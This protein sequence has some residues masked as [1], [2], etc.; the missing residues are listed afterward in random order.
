M[1][2]HRKMHLAGRQFR[3][4]E[5]NATFARQDVYHRH[6]Q[7]IH[8]T[9][10]TSLVSRTNHTHGDQE[11]AKIRE[12]V[13]PLLSKHGRR[14]RKR[15][16]MACDLCW[17]KKERCDVG[18]PMSDQ[19]CSNCA[20]QDT[21]CRYSRQSNKIKIP[22]LAHGGN[23]PMDDLVEHAR[24]D[25]MQSQES[26]VLPQS[27]SSSPY[28][29]VDGLSVDDDS[30]QM[31]ALVMQNRQD[32]SADAL[33]A[34]PPDSSVPAYELGLFS[35]ANAV[36][37]DPSLHDESTRT[38]H[39]WNPQLFSS[40]PHISTDIVQSWDW[41]MDE[42]I[43]SSPLLEPHRS[44]PWSWRRPDLDQYPLRHRHTGVSASN[45]PSL[46][47]PD[48]EDVLQQPQQSASLDAPH[49]EGLADICAGLGQENASLAQDHLIEPTDPNCTV[50]A[51]A[52]TSSSMHDSHRTCIYDLVHACFQT[53][54]SLS[55]EALMFKQS[56]ILEARLGLKFANI[57]DDSMDP[58]H[59]LR[60]YVHLYFRNFH[61]LWPIL[62]V[63]LF[64]LHRC[65]PHLYLTLAIIGSQFG[66]QS[67]A[68]FGQMAHQVFRTVLIGREL[69]MHEVVESGE[70]LCLT[71]LLN[72]ATALYFGQRRSFYFAQQLRTLLLIH[73]HRICLFDEARHE[74]F[75]PP[76]HNLSTFT[77][78]DDASNCYPEVAQAEVRRRIAYG[79]VRL[80]AYIALLMGQRPQIDVDDL[81]I[82]MLGDPI[83]WQGALA[84]TSSSDASAHLDG[85]D[86][87]RSSVLGGSTV[88]SSASKSTRDPSFALEAT[89]GEHKPVFCTVIRRFY[90]GM[91]D[92]LA[93]H[94]VVDQ[95]LILF[96][97][98]P[99][100]LLL[101]RQRYSLCPTIGSITEFD[102]KRRQDPDFLREPARRSAAYDDEH[103]PYAINASSHPPS[104]QLDYPMIR[105]WGYTLATLARWRQGFTSTQANAH[106]LSA[107]DRQ[108]LFHCHI[109]YSC[110]TLHLFADMEELRGLS[111]LRRRDPHHPLY[112]R[113]L[114]W[115]RSGDAQT[116]LRRVYNTLELVVDELVKRDGAE[117]TFL[118]Y[119]V[120]YHASILLWV[121]MQ[122]IE[123]QQCYGKVSAILAKVSDAASHSP[124]SIAT[125]A[126]RDVKTMVATTMLR[127]GDLYL[128]FNCRW[129]LVNNFRELIRDL[130]QRSL[131]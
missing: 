44:T 37:T 18:D 31:P 61:P 30:V 9:A 19:Q 35:L 125:A 53:K 36:Q 87:T 51:Q 16:R 124:D 4:V 67:D 41:L 78:I 34:G 24:N 102:Q 98:V 21:E 40:I 1:R 130:A 94:R 117:F 68:E 46:A 93:L 122:L 99:K 10:R 95:E 12:Q 108:N 29:P 80:D 73:A 83:W 90:A 100:V 66:T 129:P 71:M 54:Q 57:S 38:E 127:I 70:M 58:Q 48:V 126:G 116:A 104:D 84:S 32:A 128:K 6:V 63:S 47:L 60:H 123:A 112:L 85:D 114:R 111:V 74:M 115:S 101:G 109:L 33:Q 50:T 72:M 131:L 96:G 121:S 23:K 14:H 27:T 43:P 42:F 56:S 120:I 15:S 64:D 88:G 8:G 119:V 17:K 20:R 110:L 11:A 62:P 77:T 89:V 69:D 82:S 13:S 105:E 7:Q 86:V 92:G 107:Q 22:V 106:V 5:C 28:T 26:N 76:K 103:D 45:V 91:M 81:R 59:L 3:C 25:S 2:R 39:S 65:P 49:L 52:P 55:P 118:S 113:A 97:L 75:L 79:L